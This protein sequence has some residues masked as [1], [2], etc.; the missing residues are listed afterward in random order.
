MVTEPHTHTHT[1]DRCLRS[2]AD[3]ATA[4]WA[5]VHTGLTLSRVTG[6]WPTS[7]S[8]L[9][10]ISYSVCW[11]LAPAALEWLTADSVW[12]VNLVGLLGTV[13][14]CEEMVT[15]CSCCS[16]GSILT[17]TATRGS[18]F[19]A[20][21]CVISIHLWLTFICWLVTCNATAFD[22]KLTKLKV[23]RLAVKFT[24]LQVKVLVLTNTS[25]PWKSTGEFT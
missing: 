19:I 12:M 9:A 23:L 6:L 15:H 24:S 5:C 13:S 25:L 21:D 18:T 20:T 11:L 10:V 4:N 22:K 7:L 17:Q 3:P 2:V 8:G 16:C 14:G 1:Q